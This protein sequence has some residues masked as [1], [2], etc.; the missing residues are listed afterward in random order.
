VDTHSCSR[1]LP[2]RETHEHVLR[3]HRLVILLPL[4]IKNT[5]KEH[6]VLD[7]KFGERFETYRRATWF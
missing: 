5:Y 6:L 1:P 4:Q 3:R 2:F 7:E